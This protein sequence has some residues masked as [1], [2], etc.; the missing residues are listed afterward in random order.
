MIQ[1][2]RYGEALNCRWLWNE[3]G[4]RSFFQSAF[5]PFF[6]RTHKAV[7]LF[8]DGKI[9]LAATTKHGSKDIFNNIETF[10]TIWKFRSL[11]LRCFHV[12]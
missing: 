7:S 2:M 6:S 1:S 12:R 11:A 3:L 4:F 10:S 5:R 8:V 9:R